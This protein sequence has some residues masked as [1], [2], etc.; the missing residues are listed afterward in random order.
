[1]Q[2]EMT[3]T[4]P[5]SID[6]ERSLLG[7]MLL[8]SNSAYLAFESLSADDFY[9]TQHREVYRALLS[10][11]SKNKPLDVITL[12]EELSMRGTLDGVGGAM[13][14]LD[15]SRA[16]PTTVNVKAYIKIV[17]EKSTLRKLIRACE[18][19]LAESYAPSREVEDI[20]ETAEKEIYNISMRRGGDELKH[21]NPVLMNVFDNI[22]QLYLNK[23]HISGVPTGYPGLDNAT[24]GF[25]AGEFILIGARPSMGKS[26]LAMNLV[27]HAAVYNGKKVAVFSLEMPREQLA[28]RLM[29]SYSNVKMQSVRLG[30]LTDEEWMSLASALGPI[31]SSDIYIDDTSGISVAQVRSRCRRLQLEHGL[32]MVVIDYLGLMSAN[33]G[34]RNDN[35]QGEIS[36]ISRMLKGLAQELKVPLIA[37]SQLS[38]ANKDRKDPRPMLTDLRDSGAIEQDADIVLFIHRD[39]YYHRDDP[40]VSPNEAEIIIAKQRNGPLDTIKVCWLGEYTK[41]VPTS[42]DVG[43]PPN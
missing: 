15:L 38:R 9:S 12:T 3:R 22:E 24:T 27:E 19:I 21:I 11:Q 31:G 18:S 34:S 41:F 36:E 16:V 10:M 32:D 8:D 20:L 13:A 23:G 28:L 37:L 1:M 39:S 26:S 33:A 29:C 40:N 43:E 7:C 35:R 42:A 30:T 5:H 25:H 2:E 6:A 4:M 14:V 17:D